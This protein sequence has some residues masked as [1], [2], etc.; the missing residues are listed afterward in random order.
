M[1]VFCLVFIFIFV[2]VPKIISQNSVGVNYSE[3]HNGRNIQVLYHYEMTPRQRI[4]VG[5]KY[6][7]NPT[8]K[9]Y[10][11]N[12]HLKNTATATIFLERFGLV[13]MYSNRLTKP[14][15]ESSVE[16]YWFYNAQLSR[17]P[18]KAI[19]Y[20]PTSYKNLD[21]YYRDNVA[22]TPTTFFEQNIGLNLNL[23]ITKNVL[24]NLLGGGGITLT[25]DS[26]SRLSFAPID[27]LFGL[28]EWEFSSLLSIG[29]TYKIN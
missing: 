3:V 2:C 9:F 22:Y 19:F 26:D 18:L 15:P 29:I 16:F 12:I 17:L 10:N 21:A 14:K 24:M 13:G 6:H 25:R 4:A 7:I 8:L 27:S 11:N 23:K 20:F 1:K 5:I 28:G